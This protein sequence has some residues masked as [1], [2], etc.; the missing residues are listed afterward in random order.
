MINTNNKSTM[1]I[2]KINEENLKVIAVSIDLN[3]NDFP[4]LFELNKNSL[5]DVINKIITL[6]YNSYF[7]EIKDTNII[8]DSNT[9]KMDTL[10][11]LI[12]KLTGISNNSKKIGIFG[13]NYIHD[14]IAKNFIGMSYQQTGEIDHSGD[15]LI[16][17]NNGSEILVEIKNYSTTINDDE[18]NKFT[19]DMKVTKRKF[20]LFISLGTKINKM[21]IIDLKTFIYENDIYYQFYISNLNEDLHRLEVGILLLQVLSE[22][23]NQQIKE[24]ILDESIKDKLNLLIEQINDNEVL[25]GCFLDTEK[26]IRNSLNIFYQKL[27]DNHMNMENKIKNIFTCLKDNNIINLPDDIKENELLIKYK[28]TK[29][30]NIL[31]KTIDY[32]NTKSIDYTC[33][34][35]EIILKDVGNIKILKEKIELVTKSKLKIPITIETWKMF[36]E[37]INVKS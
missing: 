18:I 6:G 36:E 13:E 5:L 10:D 12:N 9:N 29:I 20:G 22:Y 26:E 30:C 31:K 14:L 7:P 23:N 25:R 33:L 2:K 34:D 37:Q 16:T 27:R 11:L 24:F 17:L 15:G 4:R 3:Q 28:N 19:H 21:K 32:L 8:I 35:K 1:D